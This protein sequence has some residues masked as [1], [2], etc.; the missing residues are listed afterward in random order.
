M[1]A[2]TTDTVV[3]P[4]IAAPGTRWHPHDVQQRHTT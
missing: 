4:R 3:P 1:P 2:V